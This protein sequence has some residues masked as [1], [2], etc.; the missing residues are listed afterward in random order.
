MGLSA[1]IGGAP[2]RSVARRYVF[3]DVWAATRYGSSY[4]S[5][6]QQFNDIVASHRASLCESGSPSISRRLMALRPGT[7]G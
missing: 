5:A 2:L 6:G 3:A 4:R 1:V 7:E